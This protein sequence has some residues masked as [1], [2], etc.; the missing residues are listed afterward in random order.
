MFEGDNPCFATL[1]FRVSPGE[2]ERG[3]RYVAQLGSLPL[4]DYRAIE[5]TVRDTLRQGSFG[6]EVTDCAVTLFGEA[7]CKPI[8]IVADVRTLT[9]EIP[10]DAYGPVYGALLA[11]RG[12]VRSSRNVGGSHRLE[13]L[14]PL[15]EFRGFERTLSRLTRGEGEWESRA[16]GWIPAKGEPPVRERIGPNQLNRAHDLAEVARQ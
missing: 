15:A 4:A 14:I 13:C 3:L 7:Y 10:V 9:L 2:P 5:E 16:A 12:T 8:A 6:W 1:G 11:A